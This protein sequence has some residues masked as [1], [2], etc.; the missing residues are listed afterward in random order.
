MSE[1]EIEELTN[2]YH[3]R[4]RSDD[5]THQ[6]AVVLTAHDALSAHAEIEHGINHEEFTSPW[7]AAISS[8]FAFA[9]GALIPLVM[10]LLPFGEHHIWVAAVAIVVRVL[11]IGWIGTALGGAP[12]ESAVRRN[13]VT[14]TATMLTTYLISLTFGVAVA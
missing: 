4:G 8:F 11:L 12:S 13:L 6:V 1:D 10:I 14:C 2:L 9:V 7:A 3:H 5:L